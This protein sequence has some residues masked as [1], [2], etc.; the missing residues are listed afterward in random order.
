MNTTTIR[1]AF[2]HGRL[3]ITRTNV[4]VAGAAL[5]VGLSV[6]QM[7]LQNDT[8]A[9]V[10]VHVPSAKTHL[11]PAAPVATATL[12]EA[13]A[14]PAQ[15]IVTTDGDCLAVPS[16]CGYPDETNTG[17]SRD[18]TLTPSGSITVSPKSATATTVIENMDIKGSV[19][20]K[21]GNVIIRN[22]RIDNSGET[23]NKVAAI[24][25]YDGTS[26][27][28]EDS[29]IDGGNATVAIVYGNYTLTRVNLKG[30]S[31]ALR[32]DGNV[33]VTDSYIHDL[34]RQPESHNDIIQTLAGKNISFTHNTLM[35]FTSASGEGDP[36]NAVYQ[37]GNFTGNVDNVLFENNLVNGGNYT[38]NANWKSVDAGSWNVSN[39]RIVNNKFGRDFRYGPAAHID[40][41]MVFD[42]NTY[43]DNNS[44]A[45]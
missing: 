41:G 19:S 40:H 2:K 3:L 1:T 6:N 5:F 43:V 26:A 27:V 22:T 31:D 30:G 28:I 18:A 24:R 37:F 45:N 25:L 17:V 42:G 16:A 23:G 20:V 44:A 4:A 15:S 21:K 11:T 38:F 7:A 13:K 10:L 33:T 12:A 14:V 39:V 32:A 8:P 9:P 36:M 34:N 29:T 35:A